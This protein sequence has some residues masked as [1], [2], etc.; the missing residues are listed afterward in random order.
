MNKQDTATAHEPEVIGDDDWL[1]RRIHETHVRPDGTVTRGV[2]YMRGN[3]PDPHISV[4]VARLTTPMETL[5][6]GPS[7]GEWGVAQLAAR[8][9]RAEGF[10]VRHQP[11]PENYAHAKIEGDND[12]A[13]CT[14]L[15]EGTI[16]VLEPQPV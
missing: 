10:T 2:F 9:P 16:V 11:E 14:R 1:Y 13:K 7:R 8:T 12:R 6:R 5:Q 4:D 15:A 3:R